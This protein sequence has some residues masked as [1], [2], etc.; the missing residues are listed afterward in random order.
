MVLESSTNKISFKFNIDDTKKVINI[1]E[2]KWKEI[3]AD[4]PF[5]YS[6]LDDEFGRMYET[7]EKTGQLFTVFAILAIF[8]ASL[9][10]FALAA[11]MAEKRIK[12][13]GIRKVLGAS[14]ISIVIMFSRDFG[15]LVLIAFVIAVPIAWYV[16]KLW[17]Q[18]FA[19]REAPGF[20]IYAGS[21]IISLF[22]AWLT[23]SYQSLKAA[24]SNPV[25]SLRDE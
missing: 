9:G 20:W 6:F 21:G 23:V 10:L 7:E 13:I 24:I 3:A 12:E 17:L 19:Y 11:F 16:V 8:I 5:Q 2:V 22:I 1:L 4:Q 15:R 14:T 18:S 25:N